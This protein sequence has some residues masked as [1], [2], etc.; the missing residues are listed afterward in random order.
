MSAVRGDGC[1]KAEKEDG[2][3]VINE[4][5]SLIPPLWAGRMALMTA[6]PSLP[7]GQQPSLYYSSFMPPPSA[8]MT[9][10]GT[11]T[12]PCKIHSPHL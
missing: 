6:G 3:A 10:Q 4:L 8:A 9:F 7:E 11:P 12:S 1:V 5:V 2:W